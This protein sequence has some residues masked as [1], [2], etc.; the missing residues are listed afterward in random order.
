[1]SK[2]T[3]ADLT[4]Q[5]AHELDIPKCKFCAETDQDCLE[6]HH[7]V[8]RR[9]GGSNKEENLV[10]LCASCH[11]KLETLYNQRFYNKI[12]NQKDKFE[13]PYCGKQHRNFQIHKDHTMRCFE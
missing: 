6:T 11:R 4:I 3:T 2:A 5:K 13:C 9:K 10:Q 7:I 8:P 12:E 1:M